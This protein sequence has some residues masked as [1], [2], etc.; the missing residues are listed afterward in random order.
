MTSSITRR[1]VLL[2]GAGIALAAAGCSPAQQQSQT[3]PA[4][5]GGGAPVTVTVRLWDDQIQK[6]YDAGFAEFTKANP[7]ITVKTVLVPWADYFTKLRTDMSAGNA[8]DIVMM[9]SSYIQP[10]VTGN[11]IS[12]I[13]SDYSDL[14]SGWSQASIDQYTLSGK[15]YGVP[16]LTDGGIAMYYNTDLLTAAGVK[17]ADLTGLKWTPDGGAG[18]TLLPMLKKLTKDAAGKPGTDPAFDGSKPGIWGYNAAQDLQGIYYNF[19]GSNGGQF[20][21]SSGKFVFASPESAGAFTYLVNLINTAKVSPAASNTNNNGD[22]TRDQFLQ[23]KIAIFQSGVYN[24]K[25]VSDGAKFSWGIAPLPAGPA[26]PVSVVNTVVV[27]ANAKTKNADATKRVLR[28]LGSDGAAFVGKSGAAMPAVKS[29]QQSFADFWKTK[30]VDPSQFAKQGELKTL[31]APMGA[32]YGAA[33]TAWK[34]TF[35]D[36]F[37]GRTPVADG[38]AK[39][40]D[41]AN[42]AMAS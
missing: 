39:A 30:N 36:I 32:N 13:G 29:A 16:Q 1:S 23:G 6:A 33:L 15:L 11:L 8:D 17:P 18:D 12:E 7:N 20:Q 3:S 4:T 25:N 34:P 28:W 37:L 40:Q 38:L 24:L 10:Y 42:K 26:G 35:D 22:F 5:S 41:A 19:I 2:G 9:N 21:D 14:K 31:P 27:C